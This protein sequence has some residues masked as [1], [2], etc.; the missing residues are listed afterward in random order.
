MKGIRFAGVVLALALAACGALGTGIYTVDKPIPAAVQP[1]G[2]YQIEAYINQ[3]ITTKGWKADK[4]RPGELRA[5]QEWD[6]K[7]A[8]VTILYSPQRYSIRYH[9]SLN[10]DERD[11]TIDNQYNTRVRQLEAEIDRRM[12]PAG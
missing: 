9:S 7:V 10:L 2:A 6:N 11:G 5:T 3:A 1:A 12:K 8:V 4:M